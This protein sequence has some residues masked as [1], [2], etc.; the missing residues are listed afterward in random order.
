MRERSKTM[1]HEPLT[2][3]G[4]VCGECASRPQEK[5]QKMPAESFLGRIVKLSFAPDLEAYNQGYKWEHMWVRVNGVCEG[6]R[7]M[8]SL[9]NDPVS[10][11][12]LQVEDT[13]FFTTESIED[14][15]EE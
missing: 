1:G 15:Y 9:D 5:Y 4:V 14:V 2:N 8:G 7:L 10:C 13:V 12:E 11:S 3:I 6:N